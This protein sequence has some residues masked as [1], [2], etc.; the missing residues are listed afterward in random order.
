MAHSGAMGI[1]RQ[2]VDDSFAAVGMPGTESRKDVAP[3][4]RELGAG[5]GNERVDLWRVW[6]RGL[7]ERR[8]ACFYLDQ[9]RTRGADG[10]AEEL[11]GTLEQ[12]E[13][14]AAE[15]GGKRARS[16]HPALRRRREGTRGGLGQE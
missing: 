12:A 10:L 3:R 16:H 15:L 7:G 5:G 14:M 4:L 13:R 11:A 2:Y 8:D 6:L 9:G 1:L